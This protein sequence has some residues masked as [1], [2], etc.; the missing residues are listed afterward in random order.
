MGAGGTPL[1][2]GCET[3]P[4][5][6]QLRSHPYA[7]AA[8]AHGT[9]TPLPGT[10]R[11]RDSLSAALVALACLL[12][13]CT[14]LAA[15]A[16]LALTDTTRYVDTMAPLAA[17]PAVRT[18]VADTVE[19]EVLRKLAP[20][21][22]GAQSSVLAPFIR[23]AV[24]SFTGTPAFRAAWE[25]G[26]RAVHDA[27]LHALRDD[28][29]VRGPVTVDL[30]PVTA[31]LRERLTA[32]HMPYA[33]RIPVEHT[34]VAVVPAEEVAGLRKGYQVLH[35]AAFWLPLATVVLAVTGIAVAACRRRA[36][37][38]TGLGTALG[39]ALLALAVAIGRRLTLADLPDPGH[40]PAAGA[41]YDALTATLRTAAWLLLAV[42]LAVALLSWLTGRYGTRRRP[43]PP[44]AHAAPDGPSRQPPATLPRL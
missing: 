25:A 33:H 32:D 22:Q 15:W 21:A 24:H 38:A 19:E 14:A 18:A 17:D 12:T 30:A 37:T 36:L 10:V 5:Q 31:Q 11:L 40:R 6:P 23:D 16:T 35:A 8:L 26:N 1:S 28:T 39:G 13:P 7:R 41:I 44:T 27:V 2:P 4:A 42:G 20:E 43:R 29:A 3:P 34:E 9:P